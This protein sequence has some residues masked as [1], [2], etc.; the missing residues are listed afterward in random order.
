VLSFLK[1][2]TVFMSSGDASKIRLSEG[3]STLTVAEL[4]DELADLPEEC[5]V[6]LG[7]RNGKKSPTKNSPDGGRTTKKKA[8]K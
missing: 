1:A 6:M 5:E 4:V 7:C 8:R 3:L 2:I